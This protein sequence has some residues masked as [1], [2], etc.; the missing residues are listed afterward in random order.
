MQGS[1]SQPL[2]YKREIQRLMS[3][4]LQSFKLCATLSIATGMTGPDFS[5]EILDHFRAEYP[6]ILTTAHMAE[7]IHSTIG[8]VRDKVHR[9]ELR[10]LRWGQQFRFLRDEVLEGILQWRRESS[11]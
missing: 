4:H 8:D 9:G 7:M 6:L 5:D 3:F 10:A 11:E 1:E 2:K